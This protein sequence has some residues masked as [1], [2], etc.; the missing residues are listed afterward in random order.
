MAPKPS[1]WIHGGKYIKHSRDG[2]F[3]RPISST[4]VR[5]HGAQ[6]HRS[7]QAR[8]I[9]S[10]LWKH[11][12]NLLIHLVPVVS[13]IIK[14]VVAFVMMMIGGIVYGIEMAR[15]KAANMNAQNETVNPNIS[16]HNEQ[17]TSVQQ[18]ASRQTGSTPSPTTS[19]TSP[20]NPIIHPPSTT[21]ASQRATPAKSLLR[22]ASS[23]TLGRRDS[24]GSKEPRSAR[25]VLFS[26]TSEGEVHRTEVLYDKELPASARKVTKETRKS[27]EARVA[28]ANR[29]RRESYSPSSLVR[30]GHMSPKEAENVSPLNDIPKQ[31]VGIAQHRSPLA[32]VN[33][34]DGTANPANKQIVP[35][36]GN[37]QSSPL[38]KLNS[39]QPRIINTKRAASQTIVNPDQK[40]RNLIAASR[41]NRPVVAYN[42][43]G[44]RGLTNNG[45]NAKRQ[46]EDIEDWVWKAMNKKGKV[47]EE[48]V[49]DS[50]TPLKVRLGV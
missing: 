23:T 38:S 37:K 24:F 17:Q 11:V 43:H 19:S 46:R 4:P 48:V 42:R 14:T 45:M 3:G 49:L 10:T 44:Y 26:E 40:R 9:L 22:T 2:A 21:L 27:L 25:R 15:S 7:S 12:M 6:F 34:R 39:N 18:N 29:G 1:G 16:R 47:E 28:A 13:M 32:V 5:A 20:A 30:G 33:N 50:K 41:Y 35:V 36:I 31:Q 8:T